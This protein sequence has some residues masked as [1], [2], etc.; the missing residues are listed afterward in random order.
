MR[1]IKKSIIKL[2]I[3]LLKKMKILK[4]FK[5]V[6][7]NMKIAIITASDRISLE[8]FDFIISKIAKIIVKTSGTIA[9]IK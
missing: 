9:F 7:L 1:E 3:G 8:T 2:S 6:I 4:T 5:Y